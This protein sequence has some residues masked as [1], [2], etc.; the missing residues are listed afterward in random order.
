M[1]EGTESRRGPL[2][3][4]AVEFPCREQARGAQ[5]PPDSPTL[6]GFR[7]VGQQSLFRDFSITERGKEKTQTELQKTQKRFGAGP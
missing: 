2:S 1:G 3:L 6:L 4:K 5:R 7:L